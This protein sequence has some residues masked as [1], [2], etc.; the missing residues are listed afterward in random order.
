MRALFWMRALFLHTRWGNLGAAD[1]CYL[2]DEIEDHLVTKASDVAGWRALAR[3][4]RTGVEGA[5]IGWRPRRR[6]RPRETP[7]P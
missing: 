1:S 2:S 7:G 5:N 6:S 4:G 3:E